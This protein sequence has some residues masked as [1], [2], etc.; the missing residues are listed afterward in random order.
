MK[1]IFFLHHYYKPEHLTFGMFWYFHIDGKSHTPI[2]NIQ[3]IYFEFKQMTLIDMQF[4]LHM[5]NNQID[6]N[7]F[8]GVYLW[9]LLILC[10]RIANIREMLIF[11]PLQSTTLHI[12]IE[13]VHFSRFMLHAKYQTQNTQWFTW[14]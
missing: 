6:W 2:F 3:C 9:F 12:S 11:F 4:R 1:V 14:Q 5:P 7:V 8:V 13:W 10:M